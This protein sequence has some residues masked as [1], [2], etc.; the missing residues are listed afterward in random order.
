MAV[1][2]PRYYDADVLTR[3]ATS[4]ECVGLRPSP[5]LGDWLNIPPA[6]LL[7]TIWRCE[8][9]DQMNDKIKPCEHCGAPMAR[10]K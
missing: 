7:D 8:Y 4:Y 10:Q 5:G 9:C 1:A 2:Y 3:A 6:D